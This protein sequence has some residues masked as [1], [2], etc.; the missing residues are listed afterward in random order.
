VTYRVPVQWRLRAL[1]L[2]TFTKRTLWWQLAPDHDNVHI[3]PVG[4]YFGHLASGCPCLPSTE[5]T[6]EPSR[7]DTWLH[8]HHS[9]D[10][11]IQARDL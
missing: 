7:G 3:V 11:R 1:V 4:D 10:D 8:F 9:F 5:F 6:N 2:R